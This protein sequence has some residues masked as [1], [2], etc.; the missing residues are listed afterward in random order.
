MRY[1]PFW[2]RPLD[3]AKEQFQIFWNNEKCHTY[4]VQWL[5]DKKMNLQKL[6]KNAANTPKIAWCVFLRLLCRAIDYAF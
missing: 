2:I 1:I 3:D 6:S 5:N 4:L